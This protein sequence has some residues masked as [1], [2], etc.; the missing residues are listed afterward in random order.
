M[1]VRNLTIYKTKIQ[2]H[3][4]D[5]Y[6][7]DISQESFMDYLNLVITNASSYVERYNLK[8]F[9]FGEMGIYADD[10]EFQADLFQQFF[11]EILRTHFLMSALQTNQLKTQSKHGTQK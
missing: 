5:I 9:I 10:E 7:I 3:R 2:R 1:D 4:L 11:E 8:G 6:A